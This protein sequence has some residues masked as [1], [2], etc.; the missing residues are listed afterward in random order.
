MNKLL[1][2]SPSPHV[3]GD[4]SIRKI[5]Y[6]VVLAMLRGLCHVGHVFRLGKR[7]GDTH[8]RSGECILRIC[9]SKVSHEGQAHG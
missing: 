9:N 6:G 8:C 4:E 5:M 1:T 3:K 2:V 7:K